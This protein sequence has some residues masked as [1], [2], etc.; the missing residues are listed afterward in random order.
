[1][2]LKPLNTLT[3]P[4]MLFFTFVI[5]FFS[6]FLEFPSVSTSID[7]HQQ[8]QGQEQQQS[9]FNA[10]SRLPSIEKSA[11]AAFTDLLSTFSKWDSQVG[12]ARFRERHNESLTRPGSAASLQEV[13]DTCGD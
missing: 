12:C 4:L 1:M 5:L 9:L 6:G 3:I 8:R 13:G 10:G 7:Y 11:P 2:Q